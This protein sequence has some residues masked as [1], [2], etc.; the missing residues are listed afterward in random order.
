MDLTLSSLSSG[1][2]LKMN[3]LILLFLS[4]LLSLVTLSQGQLFESLTHTSALLKKDKKFSVY[5]PPKYESSTDSFPVLYLLHGLGGNET[6]WIKKGRVKQTADSLM[7]TSKAKQMVIVMPDGENTYYMNYKNGSYPF[8]DYFFKELIPW[9]E[10]NYR[11]KTTRENRFIA[12]LSMGGFGSMLY[13]LH[14]PDLFAAVAP[15]SAAI[16]TD[17]EIRTLDQQTYDGRFGAITSVKE[18]EER[19]DDFWN[20]NSIL[21]LASH[22]DPDILKS[23]RYYID[24]GDDDY[25]FHGNSSLHILFGEREVPHEYRVRDGKHTWDYWRDSLPE[26]LRFF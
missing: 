8:E 1:K 24:I 20:Y 15:L 23:L 12:G 26:V 25:L 5:L 21:F 3:K 2:N 13:A 18:G 11:V 4:L 16:R 9:I 6:D 14:R 17:E 22:L 19:I 7:I 10:A